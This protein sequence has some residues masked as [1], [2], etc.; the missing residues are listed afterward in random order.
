VKR[1]PKKKQLAEITGNIQRE[2]W[3]S[4][5]LSN[6]TWLGVFDPDKPIQQQRDMIP[7]Y[8]YKKQ[9]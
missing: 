6:Q 4:L 1:A 9:T 7:Q 5:S 2:I 8:K 3:L